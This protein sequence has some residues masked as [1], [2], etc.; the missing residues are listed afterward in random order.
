MQE[1]LENIFFLF[2]LGLFVGPLCIMQS[3]RWTCSIGV[4]LMGIGV[5]LSSFAKTSTDLYLSSGLIAGKKLYISFLLILFQSWWT[6]KSFIVHIRYLS[7]IFGVNT[8]CGTFTKGHLISE[9][10][11]DAL[12]SFEPKNEWISVFLL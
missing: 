3:H 10:L 8:T 11:L 7:F 6:S 12:S 9:W 1:K 2:F 5:I 4:S